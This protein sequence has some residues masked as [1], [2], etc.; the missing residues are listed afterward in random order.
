MLWGRDYYAW[1]IK[2]LRQKVKS[3]AFMQSHP[4]LRDEVTA[5]VLYRYEHVLTKYLIRIGVLNPSEVQ[6]DTIEIK[7]RKV[8]ISSGKAGI[9]T[10]TSSSGIYQKQEEKYKIIAT[11][12]DSAMNTVQSSIQYQG[13][14]SN[15]LALT[16]GN[17]CPE[18]ITPEGPIQ[19]QNVQSDLGSP[20]RI[21]C[22]DGWVQAFPI[23]QS[24]DGQT[25]L[26]IPRGATKQLS[27]PPSIKHFVLQQKFF[28]D[29]TKPVYSFAP[30]LYDIAP[31]ADL[32]MG[33][34]QYHRPTMTIAR[35]DCRPPMGY[36]QTIKVTCTSSLANDESVINR[37]GVT[38]DLA[39][40]PTMYFLIPFCDRDFLK[41]Q[42]E[43]WFKFLVQQITPPVTSMDL[44][45]PIYLRASFEV[46]EIDYYV[47]KSVPVLP[48]PVAEMKVGS[49]ISPVGERAVGVQGVLTVRSKT[50]FVGNNNQ[51]NAEGALVYNSPD[52]LTFSGNLARGAPLVSA[53]SGIALLNTGVYTINAA[54]VP[55]GDCRLG[56]SWTTNGAV[57]SVVW[58]PVVAKR[59][60]QQRQSHIR[61]SE[62]LG[63]PTD[64]A[65]EVQYWNNK[66]SKGFTLPG[67]NYEGPGN[68]LNNGEPTTETDAFAR[69]HDLAYAWASYQKVIGKLNDSAFEAAIHA[70]DEEFA[71]NCNLVSTDGFM[72]WVGIR[73]KK[74]VEHFTGL[75]YPSKGE[76]Q[77]DLTQDGD[78]ESNP[79][80]MFSQY[81]GTFGA[82]S[83]T[84]NF[85][86]LPLGDWYVTVYTNFNRLSAAGDDI[87]GTWVR[88]TSS[89][90]IQYDSYNCLGFRHWVGWSA[91]PVTY[92]V[93]ITNT[94]QSFTMLQVAGGNN[95]VDG[96]ITLLFQEAPNVVAVVPNPLPIT[97]TVPLDVNIASPLPLPTTGGG[98][99]PTADVNII[100]SIPLV[101]ST[102]ITSSV[103]LNTNTTIVAPLPLPTTGGGGGPTAD[104]NIISSIP[105]NTNATI[106]APLPLP[107]TGGGGGPTADVNIISSVPLF[108][109]SEVTNVPLPVSGAAALV[110]SK[111]LD[112][113]S[114]AKE[115]ADKIGEELMMVCTRLPSEDHTPIY[116]CRASIGN[117]SITCCGLGKKDAKQNACELLCMRGSYQADF[118][119]AAAEP[120]VAMD[121]RPPVAQG[122]VS[123]RVAMGQTVGNSEVNISVVKEDFIPI[124]TYSI[125][126]A[127]PTVFTMRIAPGNFTS[128]GSESQAQQPFRNHLFSGPIQDGPDLVYCTFKVT[129]AANYRQNARLIIAHV[130]L[131]YT[132]AGVNALSAFDLKQFPNREHKLHGTETIFT[133]Q[134]V[135]R[136]PTILN[137]GIGETNTNGWLTCRILEDSLTS[138]ET[139]PKLTLWVCANKVAQSFGVTPSLPTPIVA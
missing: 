44:P 11:S 6:I 18:E 62:I 46:H 43:P 77:K 55:T 78:V 117:D 38:Y 19:Y 26:T 121:T 132:L 54:L 135:N 42:G 22:S 94:N 99:G 111:A 2:Q 84:Y 51:I 30:V 76:Y 33:A 45:S 7:N 124:K 36:A 71:S 31:K 128:D 127:A 17:A 119:S 66:G 82:L 86:D 138:T 95:L 98:V 4:L 48:E 110:E 40:N 103:P 16:Y 50:S 130:P 116:E 74:F 134:W 73:A 57:P 29:D 65:F 92:P 69:K 67:H 89:G 64:Q 122:V 79:G 118:D 34:F 87:N 100:S 91:W 120:S 47:H 13:T 81:S 139:D 60:Q 107:T 39:D 14:V 12:L 88:T 136:L 133:P 106:V 126:T 93:T 20:R 85:T 80:P 10:D 101:T 3:R 53:A 5:N 58:T 32:L 125:T 59:K 90:Q 27:L 104:V 102:N 35:I 21:K 72:G 131:E 137:H 23:G 75:I 113:V 123:S 83:H 68:S 56:F 96:S 115:H 105:L 52:S 24:D 37:K 25:G 9:T 41:T 63:H 1:F 61:A 49:L 129:S 114:R 109:F 28:L 97:A 8:T 108:T 15:T 112:F 70:A